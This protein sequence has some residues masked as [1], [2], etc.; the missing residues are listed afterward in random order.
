M[1]VAAS[2]V[3]G[4]IAS[5][6]VDAT[7]EYNAGY[8]AGYSAGYSDG[9]TYGWGV[10]HTAGWQDYYDSGWW[11]KPNANSNI[12]YVPNRSATGAEQWFT[13]KAVKGG[14]YWDQP[15]QYYIRLNYNAQASVSDVVVDTKFCQE[16]HSFNSSGGIN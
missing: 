12:C 4:S 9:T 5:V 10:G 16:S 2:G 15:A 3:T 8:N 14:F 6:T 1:Y 13:V 7:S 11:S